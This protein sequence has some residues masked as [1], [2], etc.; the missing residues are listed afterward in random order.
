LGFKN[1]FGCMYLSLYSLYALGLIRKVNE[2]FVRILTY[3]S[4]ITGSGQ[5]VKV[6]C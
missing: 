1:S 6:C 4:F 5:S 2:L 3:L